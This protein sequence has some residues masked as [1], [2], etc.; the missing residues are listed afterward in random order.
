MEHSSNL[1]FFL[2]LLY[3]PK[4][5]LPLCH[6][7]IW[8]LSSWLLQSY[9]IWLGL[10]LN[11]IAQQPVQIKLLVMIF[12]DWL[13]A[14]D[15]SSFQGSNWDPCLTFN[16]SSIQDKSQL[17]SSCY[18]QMARCGRVLPEKYLCDAESSEGGKRDRRFDALIAGLAGKSLTPLR[19]PAARP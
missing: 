17:F 16:Y 8:L 10:L 3:S 2:L 7:A 11:S 14:G 1:Y 18:F 9:S 13:H 15:Y 4:G 5:D 6:Y 19:R 12:P